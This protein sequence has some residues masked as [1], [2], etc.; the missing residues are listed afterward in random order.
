MQTRYTESSPMPR[1]DIDENSPYKNELE[2]LLLEILNLGL[3]KG[4][5]SH[6]NLEVVFVDSK[7]MREINRTHRGKD[8]TT[9]VLSFPL[10]CDFDFQSLDD[11]APFERLL[12]SIVINTELAKAMSESYNHTLIDEI[13]LL[14]I[15]GFLHIL[16]FDHEVDNG[17]QRALEQCIIESIG[18]KQSLIVRVQGD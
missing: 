4:D 8:S 9:D 11:T 18:L 3:I 16:G 15:H 1:L 12:G 13:S 7:T 10:E 5:F 2:K 6:C 14:F 17:E